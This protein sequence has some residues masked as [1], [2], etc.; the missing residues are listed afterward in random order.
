MLLCLKIAD[1]N[2]LLIAEN[3][4]LYNDGF[5][6]FFNCRVCVPSTTFIANLME[7]ENKE[8]NIANTKIII[9]R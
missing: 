7:K 3:V 2:G 4:F 9:R 5:A 1:F 6:L 8:N